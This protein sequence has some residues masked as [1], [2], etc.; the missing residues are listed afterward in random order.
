MIAHRLS[1]IQD[2]DVIVVLDDGRVVEVGSHAELLG[3][4][5]R[6]ANMWHTQL[7]HHGV[8]ERKQAAILQE[9]QGGEG[10]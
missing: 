8:M 6:Y 7:E 2:A 10:K 1:T 5:Q 9:Q 3:R 4:G